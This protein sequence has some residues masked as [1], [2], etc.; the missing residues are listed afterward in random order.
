MPRLLYITTDPIALRVLLEGQLAHFREV[1]YEVIAIAAP[2]ADLDFTGQ[3][4]GIQVIGLP[5]EREIRPMRDLVSL[6]RMWRL[7]RRLRPDIVCTAT[8]KASLLGLIAAWLARVPVRVYRLWG[9]RLE[10][11]GGT[12]R[13][14]LAIAEHVCV[15]CSHRVLSISESLRTAFI[16]G[17]FVRP[18]KIYVVGNGS[19]NGIKTDWFTQTT[20]VRTLARN[21]RKQWGVPEDAPVLGFVGRFVRDKGVAELVDAFDKVLVARPDAW[22][23]LVG[24]YEAGDQVPDQYV[25]RIAEHPRIIRPGFIQLPDLGPYYGAMTV[26]AFPTHR[27]GFGNVA[28][29]ASAAELPVVTYRSTGAVDAVQDGIT[30]TVVELRDVDALANAI[31]RYFNDPQLCHQHGQAGRRRAETDFRPEAIWRAMEIHFRELLVLHGKSLPSETVTL[32]DR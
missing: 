5:M 19:N 14:I 7:M 11:A 32:P 21:L 6:W 13:R 10:T 22:L 3:R 28:V 12:K 1:G 2:G 27:E 26:F 20:E 25:R 8:S 23:L 29:E 17:G 4:D 16:A 30:G 18:E 24:D 15:A 31:L 9:L